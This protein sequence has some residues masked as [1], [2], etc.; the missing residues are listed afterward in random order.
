MYL[1][2]DDGSNNYIKPENLLIVRTD[3]IGDVVLSLPLAEIVKK[4]FPQ[5]KIT[6]LLRD[7]TKSLAENHPF[8]DEII[9]L[10]ESDHKISL[11]KN[12][13]MVSGKK[14]DSCVIVYPTFLTALI[15]FLS[16]IK[17]RIG[18][19]FRWYSLL[20]NKKIYEHRKYA[21]RHELEY[22]VNLLRH[23]GIYEKADYGSINFNV[24][25]NKESLGEVDNL[26]AGY[27]IQ[28]GK[29]LIIIH[30]GSGG[31]SVDLPLEKFK[32]L[33]YLIDSN[34]D[35]QILITG[36]E[37]EREM[38]SKLIVNERIINFAGLL[39]LSQV[40]ALISKCGIFISNSTG[41]IH[42]AAA[43]GKYTV[44]FYPNL[45]ACSARRW[46]P[47]TEKKAVFTPDK[48]CPDCRKEQCSS[49][50]CMNTIKVSEAFVQI[51]KIYKFIV[52]NGELN[53]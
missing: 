39:N 49:K 45:L 18:T 35:A 27:K 43:L 26:L 46:G 13:K 50:D 23:F 40:I 37:N 9:I 2:N 1:K 21:E 7:Y 12:I 34:L 8:I 30:P 44:G 36:T 5:C 28:T 4:Y 3:R 22:N 32:E 38:C 14:F 25:I 47:Y 10:H 31:S 41:P 17:R 11:I 29:P 52:N 48:Q 42:I 16:G 24:K 51:E 6:F 33:I 53:A 15:I 20:F 19:G